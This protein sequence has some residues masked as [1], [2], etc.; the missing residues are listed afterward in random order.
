M[1]GAS[2]IF[3]RS[4]AEHVAYRY[5]ESTETAIGCIAY[6]YC[7]VGAYSQLIE[8]FAADPWAEV[9]CACCMHAQTGT[10]KEAAFFATVPYILGRSAK[11]HIAP[12]VETGITGEIIIKGPVRADKT[13]LRT[14]GYGCFAQVEASIE[15]YIYS[16]M[17]C[18]AFFG[19]ERGASAEIYFELAYAYALQFFGFLS[20]ERHNSCCCHEAG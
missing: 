17:I 18:M 10:G 5:T 19:A 2:S 11:K 20:L 15:A 9:S 3:F 4:A 6:N 7:A 12:I 14:E 13:Y 16:Y 8:E 1:F